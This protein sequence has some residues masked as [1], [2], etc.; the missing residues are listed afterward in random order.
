MKK[1]MEK[2]E[3]QTKDLEVLAKELEE[4]TKELEEMS[5]EYPLGGTIEPYDI[6]ME[7]ELLNNN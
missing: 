3:Q 2:I 6:L 5:E 7:E 1:L 4:T